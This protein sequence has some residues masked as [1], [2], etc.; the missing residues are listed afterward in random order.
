MVISQLRIFLGR[1]EHSMS[2]L[3]NFQG[4]HLI[5]LRHKCIR[6]FRA[7]LRAQHGHRG[8]LLA[9]ARINLR[10]I[11]AIELGT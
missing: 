8:M 5:L 1:V 2:Y 11:V 7:F 10:R 4:D 3:M 9:S 6:L